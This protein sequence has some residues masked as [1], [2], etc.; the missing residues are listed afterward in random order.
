MNLI[1]N[2]YRP[3]LTCG[4]EMW[5]RAKE[6][7]GSK[8]AAHIFKKYS[9]MNHERQRIRNEKKWDSTSRVSHKYK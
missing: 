3:I 6:D 4:G 8:T 1:E 7:I 2:T 5:T 9:R